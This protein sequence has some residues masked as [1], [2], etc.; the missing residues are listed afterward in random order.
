MTAFLGTM[1]V[2]TGTVVSNQ[3]SSAV[4]IPAVL[5]PVEL[6]LDCTAQ[7]PSSSAVLIPAVL[8]P[9]ELSLDCTAQHWRVAVQYTHLKNR[10]GR[11]CGGA[12]AGPDL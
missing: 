10:S 1:N 2:Y 12:A 5:P 11:V 3:S 9:V 6:S 8:P 4:L 7:N